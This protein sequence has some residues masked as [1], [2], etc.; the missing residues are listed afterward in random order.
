MNMKGSVYILTTLFLWGGEVFGDGFVFP[1]EFNGLWMGYPDF[2]VL[3][4]YEY[5]YTFS[6][7]PVSNGDSLMQANIV[8]D[9]FLMGWQRFYVEGIS[10]TPGEMWYCGRFANFSKSKA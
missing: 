6:I 3:G 8:I 5:N 4:P 7:S 10:D 1:K 2:N 9:T